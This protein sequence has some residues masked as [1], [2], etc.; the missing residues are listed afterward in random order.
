MEIIIAMSVDYFVEVALSFKTKKCSRNHP[1][2]ENELCSCYHDLLD[3]RRELFAPDKKTLVYQPILFI[4][5]FIPE[6]RRDSFCQNF[7]EYA[8][9]IMNYKKKPCMYLLVNKVCDR[10]KFCPYIHPHDSLDVLHQYQKKLSS[11]SDT[12]PKKMHSCDGSYAQPIPKERNSS[13]V[14]IMPNKEQAYVHNALVDFQEDEKHEFKSWS[15]EKTLEGFMHS[16]QE[17]ICAFANTN[18]GTI[19]IGINEQGYVTGSVC[20]R[21]AAD[22]IRLIVDQIVSGC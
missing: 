19:Y 18:G 9:H 1:E 10:L 14:H 20:D 4:P 16:L 8:Y 13:H 11:I 15:F 6:D 17:D 2:T 3:K 22:K 7:S 12:P 5:E 21:S